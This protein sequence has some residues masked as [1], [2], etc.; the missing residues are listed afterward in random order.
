VR[1]ALLI[2]PLAGAGL[3][4]VAEFSTLYEV[5][6]GA[7][8]PPGASSDAGAHH[9]YALALVAAAAAVMAVGAVRGRSRPAA[10]ALAVLGAAALGVALLADRPV[11][12]DTG[13]YGETY[14]AARAEAGPALALELVGGAAILAGA[15]LI[16]L[17]PSRPG[18]RDPSP[19]RR[20]ASAP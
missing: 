10:V 9:G 17:A 8:V 15:V 3:L 2:L 5:H 13:L 7:T 19:G 14:A 4:V 18:R 20:A 6:V 16:L 1:A 11:T 12:D